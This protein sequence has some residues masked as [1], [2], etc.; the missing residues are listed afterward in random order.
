MGDRVSRRTFAEQLAEGKLVSLARFY[1]ARSGW[2][3]RRPPLD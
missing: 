2:H 3:T 1:Q